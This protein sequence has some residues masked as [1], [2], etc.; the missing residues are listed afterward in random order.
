LVP[1]KREGPTRERP[2]RQIHDRTGGRA[3]LLLTSDEHAPYETAIRQ[4]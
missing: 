3:D 2:I 4:V 1:G